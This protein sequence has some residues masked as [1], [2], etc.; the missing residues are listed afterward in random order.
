MSPDSEH[1]SNSASSPR[2]R[3]GERARVRGAAHA[4]VLPLLLGQLAGTAVAWSGMELQPPA[5]PTAPAADPAAAEGEAVLPVPAATTTGAS[6]KAV[7]SGSLDLVEQYLQSRGLKSLLVEHLTQ[8]FEQATGA[9][10]ARMGERLARLMFQQLG[11][12]S[13]LAERQRLEERAKVFIRSVAESKSIGLRVEL[14]R[15]SYLRAEADAELLRVA[16]GS[17]EG[18]PLLISTMNQ[19]HQQ[20]MALG[21]EATRRVRQLE[22]R[23][24]AGKS[25]PQDDE[26]VTD[27]RAMR[28]RAYYFAGWAAVYAGDLMTASASTQRPPGVP[29]AETLAASALECFGWHTGRAAL[30]RASLDRLPRVMLKHEHIARAVLGVSAALSL[31]GQDSESL[32]WLETIEAEP[33]AAAAAKAAAP[34]RRVDVLMNAA[35][36]SDARK[37]LL[38]LRASGPE[39]GAPTVMPTATDPC[40]APAVARHVAATALRMLRDSK[41]PDASGELAK[42]AELALSDLIATGRVSDVLALAE[43]YGTATLSDSGFVG[44]FVRGMLRLESALGELRTARGGKLDELPATEPV[45]VNRLREAAAMLDAAAAQPDA[46]KF[47]ADLSR[48]LYNAARGLYYAGID[49]DAAERGERAFRLAERINPVLA[50]DSLWL[51]IVATEREA[52]KPGAG[53]IVSEKLGST[54]SLFVTRFPGS[55]RAATL[56]VR[57]PDKTGLTDAQAVE[58]LLAVDAG[59]PLYADSR[60][61]AAK[62]LYRMFREHRPG[63]AA[64]DRQFAARRFLAVAEAVLEPDRRAAM[65]A[66]GDA[67][68]KQAET[69]MVLIRQMLDATLTL[70]PPDTARSEQLL[71]TAESLL[72]SAGLDRSR[73]GRELL[74]RRLQ[75]AIGRRDFDRAEVLQKEIEAPGDGLDPRFV[76]SGRRLLYLNASARFKAQLAAKKPDEDELLREAK[77][78]V[79][80][81]R[82]LIETVG[83]TSKSM[84]DT[85]V[86]VLHQDVASAAQWMYDKTGESE[87]RELAM[88]LDEAV[89]AVRPTDGASVSRMA[90]LAEAAGDDAKALGYW[91]DLANTLPQTSDRWFEARFNTIRLMAK[92]DPATALTLLSQHKVLNPTFGPAPWDARFGE[93]Q[94]KLLGA[95]PP[96][97]AT[98]PAATAPAGGAAQP[99]GGG[100]R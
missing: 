28:S 40:L 91:R 99:Q 77:A 97:A 8:R 96:N 59:S 73:L 50:Q 66:S 42:I 81:G 47:P 44:V 79:N 84:T 75:M 72:S 49:T 32:R 39:G 36:Y 15:T 89:L 12:T 46:G 20:L 43:R 14:A 37:L 31:L 13:D 29:T 21:L 3:G 30:E 55:V 34:L 60:R 10:R 93:L 63:T 58:T 98:P 17:E 35:R 19:L 9:E 48:A 76:E 27:A 80:H 78:V 64:G 74:F 7:P 87:Y 94:A 90:T 26:D 54:I 52:A 53:L 92:S 45:M 70:E 100:G 86:L 6:G 22:E 5:P 11:A 1:T 24:D 4:A 51:A 56:L 38:S 57:R 68:K 83:T 71:A 41:P 67:G 85:S 65:A 2:R 82:R 18:R 62:I 61:T 25:T 88:R 16:A 33:L 23:L 69:V 95:Q